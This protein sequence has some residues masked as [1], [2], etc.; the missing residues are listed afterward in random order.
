V[1]PGVAG[2]VS[3]PSCHVRPWFTEKIKLLT[4]PDVLCLCSFHERIPVEITQACN[5]KFKEEIQGYLF[6]VD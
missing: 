5:L 3:A 1:V 6:W 4:D 2:L